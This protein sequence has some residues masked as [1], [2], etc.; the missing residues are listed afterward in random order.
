MTKIKW[1]KT[2]KSPVYP[3]KWVFNLP[4]VTHPHPY[5]SKS[6]QNP[7][8]WVYNPKSLIP[9]HMGLDYIQTHP[10]GYNTHPYSKSRSS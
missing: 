9:T 5:G 8:K 1:F 2:F 4:K 3:F 6:H 10:Y 7:P